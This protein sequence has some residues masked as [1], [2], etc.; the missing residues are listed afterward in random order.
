PFVPA[1]VRS[2]R[3]GGP[4]GQVAI[5]SPEFSKDEPL[6]D[7]FIQVGRLRERSER[8][9]RS[10]LLVLEGEVKPAGFLITYVLILSND[11]C[12]VSA[13]V[14]FHR[15]S[16]QQRACY[17]TRQHLVGERGSHDANALGVP[18]I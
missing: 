17:L 11:T 12:D 7:E 18:K 3:V 14:A 9:P 4:T 5:R 15:F 1:L 8:P 13:N 16:R 6:E 2:A 10:L